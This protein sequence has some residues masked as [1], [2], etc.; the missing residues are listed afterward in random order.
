MALRWRTGGIV[1]AGNGFRA[2]TVAAAVADRP[3]L[4]SCH[5]L[6]FEDFRRHQRG[7]G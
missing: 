3:I 7:G 4:V 2:P 5:S 6:Q 1:E